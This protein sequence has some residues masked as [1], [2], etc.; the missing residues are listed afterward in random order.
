M[1]TKTPHTSTT[2]AVAILHRKYVAD[3]PKMQ[4]LVE[5]ERVNADVAQQIYDLRQQAGLTQK[6][7]AKLVKTSTSAISRLESAD[8]HGHSLSMLLRIGAALGKRV[9]VRFVTPEAKDAQ[10]A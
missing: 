7:L 9:Q 10:P 6:E 3:N 8:Y 2:D 5:A 1:S 4:Q